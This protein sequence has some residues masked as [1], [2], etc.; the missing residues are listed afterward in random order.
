MSSDDQQLA[1]DGSASVLLNAM[2][3]SGEEAP[4]PLTVILPG[5][6]TTLLAARPEFAAPGFFTVARIVVPQ[7]AMPDPSTAH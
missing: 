5:G 1:L 3:L 7:L 4:Y 6:I 2:A